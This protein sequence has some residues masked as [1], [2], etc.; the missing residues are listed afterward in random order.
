MTAAVMSS[1]TLLNAA[2]AEDIHTAILGAW[3]LSDWS[4]TGQDGS[5][6]QPYGPN[7]EGMIMY[8]ADGQMAVQMADPSA[9]DEGTGLIEDRYFAYYGTYVIDE[10]A[11]TVTHSL[12]GS[13]T[14]S[15]IGTKQV[16]AYELTDQDQLKL[17]AIIPPDD[18]LAEVVG[19]GGKNTLVW[20]RPD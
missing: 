9:T 2:S 4:V 15:W 18:A 14:P 11:G 16:R 5:V 7:A 20:V 17:V 3:V 10:D 1:F 6:V 8:T 13:L 19:A 12:E